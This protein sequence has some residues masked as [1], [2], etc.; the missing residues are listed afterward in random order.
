MLRLYDTADAL[1]HTFNHADP[2]TRGN[3]PRVGITAQCRRGVGG[4]I[5]EFMEEDAAVHSEAALEPRSFVKIRI[6]D[7]C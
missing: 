2:K 6:R 1:I 5:N 3:K 4:I 7:L